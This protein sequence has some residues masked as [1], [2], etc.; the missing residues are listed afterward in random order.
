MQAG[1]PQTGIIKTLPQST[2]WCEVCTLSPASVLQPITSAG[3]KQHQKQGRGCGGSGEM[4]TVLLPFPHARASSIHLQPH[5]CTNSLAS[6]LSAALRIDEHS[7][8][9]AATASH[10]A[11]KLAYLKV[12]HA[13]YCYA[14]V[15]PHSAKD[16]D[17]KV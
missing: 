10:G 11:S 8:H 7:R 14:T 6:L 16:W 5:T 4:H 2:P 9:N 17:S 13:V 3:R 12:I 15:I 1:S